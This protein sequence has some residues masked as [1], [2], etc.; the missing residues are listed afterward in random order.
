[1][2]KKDMII[3]SLGN[4]FEWFD[5][6]M[7]IYLAPVLGKVFFP[8]HEAST[9]TL[10]A[11]SVFASGYLFR[12]LGGIVFGYIGDVSGRSISLRSSIL[13]ISIATL[14][15]GLLPSYHHAGITASILFIVLRI[16]QGISAGGEYSGVMVYLAETAP[17][18]KRGVITSFA[19]SGANFGFML[20]TLSVLA[21]QNFMPAE[22]LY[23]WGWR[24]P[25]IVLGLG[26]FVLAYFRFKLKESA[27]FVNLK[28]HYHLNKKSL[29]SVLRTAP[30]AMLKIL[31]LTC[32]SSTFYIIYFGYLSHYL[33][34]YS[35]VSSNMI[36]MMQ[37]LSLFLLAL[38]IPV[39]GMLGDRFGCRTMLFIAAIGML[40]FVLPSFYLFQQQALMGIV[41]VWL[42]ATLLSLI[43]QGN[44]LATFVE[45]SPPEIRYT[46]VAFSYNLG[47]AL[48]G[49][50]A[51]LIAEIITEKISPFA[52][53][54]F[55]MLTTTVGLITIYY[56]KSSVKQ[57]A[58]IL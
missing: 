1:M 28:L 26:G 19:G 24:L 49:G 7:F 53:G 21:L 38:F 43:D 39:G 36:L 25:F 58:N 23:H 40:I 32:M 41:I 45:I 15:V 51:P 10:A 47:N 35:H 50:T 11:F 30:Y 8:T 5:F 34:E 16:L 46:C 57:T 56:L 14:I 22:V 48:F 52:P 31:G 37:F 13:M 55:L 12:P 33:D 27:V 2:H 6:G 42:V 44:N 17:V 20:A 54:Y 18:K 29:L 4:V 9:A 3:A